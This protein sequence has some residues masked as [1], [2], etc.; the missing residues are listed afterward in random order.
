MLP[1][2]VQEGTVRPYSE[3]ELVA[4]I[5]GEELPRGATGISCG[6]K[7]HSLPLLFGKSLDVIDKNITHVRCLNITDRPVTIKRNE[8]VG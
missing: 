7:C 3:H 4:C 6:V 2:A 1:Y 8:N 5:R